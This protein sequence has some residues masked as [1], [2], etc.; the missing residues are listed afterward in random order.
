MQIHNVPQ[1]NF[2]ENKEDE[3][4]INLREIFEN[5]IFNW[6][7]FAIGVIVMLIGAFCIYDIHLMNLRCPLLFS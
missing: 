6:K 3:D 1:N 2:V 4:E 5:Y 7:W